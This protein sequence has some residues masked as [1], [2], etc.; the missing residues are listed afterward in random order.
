[1]TNDYKQLIQVVEKNAFF[2]SVVLQRNP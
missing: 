1:M 2:N